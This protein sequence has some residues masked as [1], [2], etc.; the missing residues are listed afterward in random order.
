MK[1]GLP[2]AFTITTLAW[3]TITYEKELRATGELEN[4]RAAIRWGTDYFLK[5][6][7]R[8][9]RLY[10]QVWIVLN[11]I[12]THSFNLISFSKFDFKRSKTLIF[13]F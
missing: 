8:R 10:V 1:Y 2:M 11:L 9:N 13:T 4:A 12:F 3:S 7:S 6:A 5:C